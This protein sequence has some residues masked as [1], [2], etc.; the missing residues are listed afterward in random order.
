MAFIPALL[1]GLLILS[2]CAESAHQVRQSAVYTDVPPELQEQIDTS[3]A[4][5]DLH[6]APSN[7]VG[8]VITVGGI[9]ISSKRTKVQTEIE[10]LELPTKA[11]EPSTRERLRSEGRFLAVREAILDPAS[12]PAGTPITVIGIVK[13]STTRPLDE[14]EYTYP[15]LEI[16]HLID[17]NTVASQK[18][19]GDAAAFYGP[20]YPPYGY[21]GRPYGYYPYFGRPYYPFVIR[22]RPPSS[23]PP[24]RPPPQNIPPQF[25][26]R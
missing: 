1:I 16:K 2:S 19:G 15:I 4:F 21:W 6:A 12:V 5:A 18:S 7:Y 23:P 25:R 20:Y 14:S 8:R 17:W 9:V 10:I 24:P 13:G 26:K 3:V 22:P 11:G